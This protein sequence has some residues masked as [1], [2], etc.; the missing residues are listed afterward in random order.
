MFANIDDIRA[1][2][3]TYPD[4]LVV[5]DCFAKW[6]GPCKK[7]SPLVERLEEEYGNRIIVRKL[8]VDDNPEFVE[9]MD[10]SAMP[11]FVF[12]KQKQEVGRVIGANME[13]VHEA[14]RANI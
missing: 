6:C 1:L 3:K 2:L 8:D 5:V 12:L 14:I 13:A 4:V 10:I 11:T 7:I 9:K